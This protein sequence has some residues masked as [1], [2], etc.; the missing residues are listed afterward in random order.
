SEV[1]RAIS[2]NICTALMLAPPYIKIR[3]KKIRGGSRTNTFFEF[4][5]Q[6]T[7]HFLSVNT[8]FG[9]SE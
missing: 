8:N 9:H 4:D 3:W 1:E 2:R 7:G 6:E 5:F